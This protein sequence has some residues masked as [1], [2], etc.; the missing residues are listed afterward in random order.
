[1]NDV[2]PFVE[3]TYRVTPDKNHRAIAG[4]SMGGAQTIVTTNHN[5]DLFSYIGAFSPAGATQ[6]D[7]F[8]TGLDALKKDGLKFY[9]TGAGDMDFC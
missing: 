4:L 3:K 1:M 7:A 6:E 2:I 9:G 8:S 5:P